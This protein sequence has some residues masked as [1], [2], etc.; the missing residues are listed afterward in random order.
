MDE[1]MSILHIPYLSY[2]NGFLTCRKILRRGTFGFTSHQKE[3]VLR[4]F[5]ALENPSPLSG[6]NP[7]TLGPVASTL[8]TAPPRRLL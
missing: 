3:V 6:L 1:R 2:V 7:R 5:M 4:I 8:T